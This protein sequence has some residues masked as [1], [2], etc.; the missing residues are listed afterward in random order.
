MKRMETIEENSAQRKIASAGFFWN[1]VYAGLNAVQS[2][3]ILFAISR[4]RDIQI[5]GIIT[6]GFTGGN[7]TAIIARYGIRNYMVTDTHEQF[8]FSDYF[9][10]RI[11]TEVSVLILSFLYFFSKLISEILL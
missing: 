7:L 2:A 6:I 4:T 8:R 3:V 11:I 9:F 1:A 10:C 5:A